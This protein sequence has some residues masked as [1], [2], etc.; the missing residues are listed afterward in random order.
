[1]IISLELMYKELFTKLEI[2]KYSK[3]FVN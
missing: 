2:E 1:V 3:F